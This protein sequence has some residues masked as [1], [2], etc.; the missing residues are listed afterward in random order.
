MIWHKEELFHRAVRKW[1]WLPW[2]VVNSV[3]EGGGEDGEG[4]ICWTEV[5][6]DGFLPPLSL[7][8][9]HAC[10]GLQD[11]SQSSWMAPEGPSVQPCVLVTWK[12]R[13]LL[14]GD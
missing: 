11:P 2:E 3:Q 10:L 12:K 13:C 6:P 4:F 1:N 8:D 7:C 9:C 14:G 5:E